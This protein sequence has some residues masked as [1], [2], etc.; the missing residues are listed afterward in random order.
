[1]NPTFG[2]GVSMPVEGSGFAKVKGAKSLCAILFEIGKDNLVNHGSHIPMVCFFC[3]EQV[4]FLTIPFDLEEFPSVVKMLI[5]KFDA[6]GVGLVSEAWT[7][8]LEPGESVLDVQQRPSENP[9]RKE[10]FLV[11]TEWK[12]GK[13]RHSG[14]MAYM[15]RDEHGQLTG[16]L[17]D[18]T[19]NKAM[20]NGSMTGRLVGFFDEAE[21]EKSNEAS[22]S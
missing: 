5:Q 9:N 10:M 15:L 16:F 22:N 14:R 6:L 7:V 12:S 18:D 13:T 19:K 2:A 20:S 21:K 11:R 8:E 3:K 4:H 17:E 1:M